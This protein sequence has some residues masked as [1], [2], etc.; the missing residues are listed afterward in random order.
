MRYEQMLDDPEVTLA[1][2]A[3]WLGPR[4]RALEA[5]DEKIAAAG[6]RCRVGCRPT[7]SSELPEVLR[8]AVDFLDHARDVNDRLPAVELPP[9]PPWMADAVRQRRDYEHLYGRYLAT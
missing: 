6:P 5:S 7:R 2:L 9:A 4:D 1:A 3:G 8:H